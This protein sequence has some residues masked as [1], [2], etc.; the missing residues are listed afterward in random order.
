M[1]AARVTRWAA[2]G[3]VLGGALWAAGFYES[4]NYEH[5]LP[6][7]VD[8]MLVTGLVTFLVSAFVLVGACLSL[9]VRRPRT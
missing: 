7:W 5:G 1:R 8:A 3:V 9:I 4:W 2:G 6:T